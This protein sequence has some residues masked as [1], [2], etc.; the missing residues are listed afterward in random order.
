M[1]VELLK[2]AAGIDVTIVPYKG[3]APAMQDLLAGNIDVLVDGVVSSLPQA[4]TG[5]IK[6]LGI[7]SSERSPVATEVP[8]VAETIPGFSAVAWFGL[9]GPAKMPRAAVETLN[10]AA[11]NALAKADVRE[12]YA[13]AGAQPLGGTPAQADALVEVELKKWAEVVRVTGAKVE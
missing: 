8:A 9:F 4:R 11:N 2:M 6:A 3:A 13:K 10:R 5:R 12:R 7:T 1:T